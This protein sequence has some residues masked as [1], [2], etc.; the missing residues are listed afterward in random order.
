MFR[1]AL[2]ALLISSSPA[3]ACT[4]PGVF[5][6]DPDPVVTLR[7]LPDDL[8]RLDLSEGTTVTGAYTG[9][10]TRQNG[11]H[12]PVG[13]II[14]EGEV[15]S[16]NG[17]RMDGALVI[18]AQGHA[19]ITR[20]DRVGIDTLEG[21]QGYLSRASVEGTGILQ[22]HL[23]ITDGALDLTDVEDAPRFIRRILFQTEAGLGL[24]QSDGALTLYAAAEALQ[25]SCAPDMALNLDMG[26]YDFCFTGGDNCGLLRAGDLSRL[27][28]LLHFEG[29]E[30]DQ[31][32]ADADN[33]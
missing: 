16:R 17:A 9:T 3:L 33:G 13:F 15:I 11:G 1:S 7:I 19:T 21:R 12:L 26:S 29:R 10:E 2:A 31:P 6:F 24:W 30:R 8:D 4:A 27:S 32:Q 5:F 18:D 20:R 23:L 28:N 22:S 25:A 14:R